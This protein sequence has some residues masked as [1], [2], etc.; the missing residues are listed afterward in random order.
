[1]KKSLS[2]NHPKKS[3]KP[4]KK[5]VVL[6]CSNGKQKIIHYGASGY[7]HNYSPD[8]RRRFR[9]RHHCES[10]KNKLTARYWACT[11]LWS[12]SSSSLS[13]SYSRSLSRSV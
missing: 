5:K 3:W 1:M 9:A 11:D 8:A 4:E 10:A 7:G 6:A 13:P 2:C 12:P